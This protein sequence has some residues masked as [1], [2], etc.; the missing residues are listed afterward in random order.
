MTTRM[1]LHPIHRFRIA[2]CLFLG[3][4]SCEPSSPKLDEIQRQLA[5]HEQEIQA[6]KAAVARINQDIASLQSL[7]QEIQ[8][9]GYVSSVSAEG[10]GDVATGYILSF[11]N[12]HG[13][14]LRTAAATDGTAPSFSI[15]EMADGQF[16]WTLNGDWLRDKDGSRVPANGE[17]ATPLLKAD[18][19]TWSVSLDS[20]RTW[21]PVPVSSAAGISFRSV[22]T[23]NPDYVLITLSDG[24]VLQ[25]PTW[26]A[27]VRLRNQV[28]QLNTNLTSLQAIVR[29]LQD[30]DYLLSCSPF[31]EN[32]EQVG[33]LLSFA[34]SGL[35]VLYS[36]ADGKDG[37]TPRFKIEE[38]CW[39]VSYD[40][41]QTWTRMDKAV[42]ED[43]DRYI[44]D[45]D[46]SDEAF[47]T[48]TLSDGSV[49]SI[50]RFRPSD[51]VL[52]L[53]EGDVAIQA[54]ETLPV[55]YTVSGPSPE[56]I[57]VT[58]AS[59]G[60]YLAR[61]E[62]QSDTEGWILV[63][64]PNPFMDGYVIALL[65]DGDGYS[66]MR[67]IQF[68]QRE[69]TLTEGPVYRMDADGGT[70]TIPWAGNYAFTAD[71][72]APW[73][74]PV[75]TRAAFS[76]EIVLSVDPNPTE[77]PRTGIV[78]LHPEENPAYTALELVIREATASV[79]PLES[80]AMTLTV[81]PSFANDFTV[82]LPFRGEAR[83]SVDWGDGHVDHFDDDLGEAWIQ[84]TY[85]ISEPADYVVSVSGTA[86][87]MDAREIPQKAGIVSV[88]HWGNLG[89]QSVDHAFAQLTSLRSVCADT[90]GFFSQITDC[91]SLF[92]GCV[93]L[94]NLPGGLFRSGTDIRSF[95]NAFSGCSGLTSVSADL[96]EG[97]GNATEFSNMFLRCSNLEA[98]PEGLFRPCPKARRFFQTFHL[99]G[100]TDIPENLFAPCPD[101]EDLESA[102]RECVNLT[103]LPA[104]L[105]DHNRRIRSFALTFWGCWDLRGES[106]YTLVDGQKVHLYERSAHPDHFVAPVRY[107]E[108]FNMEGLE[109]SEAIREAG[110]W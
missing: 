55:R 46:L 82:V 99:S 50:P 41:G 63:T 65:D 20:G 16:Y 53:P 36:G 39:W 24:T 87:R 68:C 58:A 2:L 95:E 75:R 60:H 28:N 44:S 110:W 45:M 105:F 73:I 38:A 25:L 76:G 31:M 3:L 67:V 48:L 30:Q 97:C 69:M 27:F 56:R 15:R 61:V 92:E 98:L 84:H 40:D 101:I 104:G 51:L 77:A 83:C 32:G 35:V 86:E 9:G 34:K 26:A 96:L 81:R 42:G 14:R 90:D 17:G 54:G 8:A 49:L 85:S 57:T 43:G 93:S 23:S 5:A 19:G 100:L 37:V 47:L 64:A 21:A 89:V 106:P 59:D 6:L 12:G 91:T 29:A 52:D 80:L 94:D 74:H 78:R 4:A 7:L 72:E 62:K 13:I 102:F 88:E 18:D 108:C 79:Q 103:S 107:E 70:I 22:D 10:E 109:D 11:S 33:W 66:S 1:H 71:T